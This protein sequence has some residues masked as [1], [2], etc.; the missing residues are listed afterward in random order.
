MASAGSYGEDIPTS[1]DDTLGVV[2]GREDSLKV[3]AASNTILALV[4]VGVLV[5]QAGQY[6]AERKEMQEFEAL[7]AKKK[8]EPPAAAAGASAAA[9]GSSTGAKRTGSLRKKQ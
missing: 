4:L 9:T 1:D 3:L 5:L 2:V 6:Y 8:D 7:A